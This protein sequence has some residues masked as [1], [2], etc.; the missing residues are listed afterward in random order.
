MANYTIQRSLAAAGDITVTEAS[1][2]TDTNVSLVGQNFT[3]YGD[4]IATNFL[5]MLENFASDTAPESNARVPGTSAITGQLW[6]DT[7]NAVLK[8]YSGTGWNEQAKA[9]IATNESATLRWNN[10]NKRYQPEERVRIS[11]AG[12]LIIDNATAGTSAVTLNH[13]GTN[14]TMSFAGTTDFTISG[15]TGDLTVTGGRG[16]SVEQGSGAFAIRH[17]GTDVNMTAGATQNIVLPGSVKLQTTAS[18]AAR[19]GLNVPEAVAAPTAPVD[20][21]VWVT[22]AGEFFA[23]LNGVTVDLAAAAGGT[24]T[25]TGANDQLAVWTGA[26]DIDG[27]ANLTF[28][29]TTLA[30]TGAI[31]ATTF[32]GIASANLLDKSATETVSGQWT[33]SNATNPITATAGDIQALNGNGF[34]STDG[35]F[36][37][38]IRANTA[39]AINFTHSGTP[40]WIIQGLDFITT[41]CPIWPTSKGAEAIR[42]RGDAAS[43]STCD[44]Y[45]TFYDSDE[46]DYGAYLGTFSGGTGTYLNSRLGD[47]FLY[48]SNTE[49]MIIQSSGT[50]IRAGLSAIGGVFRNSFTT[51]NTTS[52]AITDNN[53]NQHNAGYNETPLADDIGANINTGSF[54]LSN[55]SIGKFISR[56]TSTSRSLTLNQVASIP[57]GATVLVHNGSTS[58]TFTIVQGTATLQW[59][60]GSGGSPTTGTRTLAANSVATIRKATSTTFQIWGNGIS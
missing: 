13:G 43:W 34:K 5:Q 44:S 46:S 10:T 3:G 30:V 12:S 28:N 8:V 55:L 4:E 26:S 25:G 60:D 14:F 20:G 50:T 40:D 1:V 9:N 7:A 56:T 57:I 22:A 47:L 36:S 6:Y 16:L 11:D 48:A 35:A 31:T 32:G 54:A 59:V 19:A 38:A 41:D 17:D 51:S 49:A 21:D 52:L 58:G 45:I 37:I 42:I 27:S 53:N 24:V 33:F 2:N 15:L 18:T 23:R 39:G 29:G